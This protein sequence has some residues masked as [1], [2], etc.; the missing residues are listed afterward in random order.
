[1]KTLSLNAPHLP[2]VRRRAAGV[3]AFML[4]ALAAC[5]AEN[6][7]ANAATAPS[8][9]SPSDVSEPA[10]EPTALPDAPATADAK[11]GVTAEPGKDATLA[12]AK[13]TTAE[14]AVAPAGAAEDPA[15]P[16]ADAP[17]TEHKVLI[18]GDSLA[19][20]GF[21]AL[22]ERKLDAHPQ[23]V[24]Y[25]KGKSAS[26]LARPDFF[27]WPAE[28]KKQIEFRKPDL[29]IVIMGGN[30]GQDLTRK[31]GKRVAWSDAEAWKADYRVRMDELLAGLVADNREVLWLGLPKMGL[32]SLE[33]K[34]EIIRAVQ[35][36]AIAAQ[37]D[38]ALY[39]DTIPMVT[40]DG[41]ELLAEAKV[42]KSRK[43]QP[44]RADDRIHFTMSGSEYFADQVYPKVLD[45]LQVADTS[46]AD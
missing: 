19:A 44:I 4:V 46:P 41:G 31:K 7:P 30:D 43:P 3:T 42:G 1:M 21:G 32:R 14:P 22:L 26:G 45:A 38:R 27:D 29:V 18:L 24:C 40:D 25:R 34:L 13:P 37:G 8:S 2:T 12:Q 20:T 33:A 6:A 35:T 15:G 23:I 5:R 10:E 17:P 16:P 36:E 11:G 39:V 9:A 28:A